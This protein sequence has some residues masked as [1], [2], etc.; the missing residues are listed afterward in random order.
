MLVLSAY[1]DYNPKPTATSH[2]D[3]NATPYVRSE[4]SDLTP[5]VEKQPLLP[6]SSRIDGA[7]SANETVAQRERHASELEQREIAD[8]LRDNPSVDAETQRA[9]AV[10]YRELHR[11]IKDQGL[12]ACRYREYAKE[13]IRYTLLFGTFLYLLHIKWYLTSAL[14]LGL[15]WVYIKIL[16]NH[17]V[18]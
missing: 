5:C 6:A 8:G 18:R 17:E 14:A 15:F 7:A 9:I 10:E 16:S 2:N 12:Y 3:L 1:A 4:E 13:S 11:Q